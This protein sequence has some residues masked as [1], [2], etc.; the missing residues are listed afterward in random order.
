MPVKQDLPA[1]QKNRD[2][3]LDIPYTKLKTFADWAFGVYGQKL[4]NTL[5]DHLRCIAAYKPLRASLKPICS[6]SSIS[7]IICK[8]TFDNKL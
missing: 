7:T 1:D 6:K 4:W 2:N 8:V 5:S 3:I